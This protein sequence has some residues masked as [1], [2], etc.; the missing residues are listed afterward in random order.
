ML[1]TFI[2]LLEQLVTLS[3]SCTNH[4]PTASGSVGVG[5]YILGAG[6][7]F[8]SAQYGWASNNLAAVELV[9][10]NG[11][12]ITASNTTNADVFA[13]IKGGGSNF[14]VVTTYILQAHPIGQ[15]WGGNLIFLGEDDT[16]NILSAVRNFTENYNDPKAG[17]IVTS[18]LTLWNSTNLW[19]LFLFYD[20]EQPPAGVFDEFLALDPTIN[21]CTTRS[22][23]DFLKANDLFVLHGSV[24]TIGTETTLLPP[25]DRPDIMR[26]YWDHWHTTAAK[27]SDVFGLVASLA[28]QPIP[29]S[30]AAV[31]RSRGGDLLDLDVDVDRIMFE[32]GQFPSLPPHNLPL[33]MFRLGFGAYTVSEADF[34]TRL[35]L[36]ILLRGLGLGHSGCGNGGDLLRLDESC[37]RICRGWFPSRCLPP[38]VHERLLLQTGLLGKIEARE[39][40]VCG[41]GASGRRPFRNHANTL[42]G[43]SPL[44]WWCTWN[45]I[46]TT[47][48]FFLLL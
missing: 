6:L 11:T 3:E 4:L 10:A 18:E 43:I 17:I 29:K 21:S 44:R 2:G 22:Y 13:A 30:L 33:D 38:T 25:A 40:T 24:Y 31:A 48:A 36:F 1:S 27:Y 12:M 23:S 47:L 39:P 35:R 7:S 15:I 5:G 34:L 45:L 19:V 37:Q 28:F 9:L 32:L 8:L 46:I 16:D 20:G 42:S 26:A 14:G 41:N